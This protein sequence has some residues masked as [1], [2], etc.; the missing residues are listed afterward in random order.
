MHRQLKIAIIGLGAWGKKLLAAYISQPHITIAAI[1]HSGATETTD[2]LQAGYAEIPVL[3][4]ESI[5]ADP[6]I[7]FVVIATPTRTHV[8]IASQ[9]IAAGKSVHIEKP[10]GSSSSEITELIAAAKKQHVHIYAGYIFVHHPVWKEIM[11]IL[12]T[13]KEVP[14]MLES[15]W[16]K[17]GT[18]KDTLEHTLVCHDIALAVSLFG[19]KLSLKKC[20]SSG[21]KTAQDIATYSLSKGSVV[22]GKLAYNRVSQ[23]KEKTVTV[24]RTNGTKLVWTDATLYEERAGTRTSIF[25]ADTSALE[26]EVRAFTLPDSGTRPGVTDGT[27]ALQVRAILEHQ[28]AA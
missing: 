14:K 17:Y 25:E 5:C 27:F 21:V 7:S 10:L 28:K 1:C 23:T 20:S 19:P 22:V 11:R 8:D 16:H 18:F 2:W 3:S 4:I 26:E 24:H 12:A 15:T 6:T 9:L 13:H